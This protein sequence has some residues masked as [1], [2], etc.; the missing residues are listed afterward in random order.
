MIK[1][2][3]YEFR[4][5]LMSKLIFVGITVVMEIVFLVGLFG[6]F[7]KTMV[8]GMLGLFFTALAGIAFMGIESI[9]TLNRDLTTKQSYMLFMTP[10][11][12]YKILGAKALENG[13]AVLL[14]GAFFGGLAALDFWL[15]GREIDEVVNIVDMLRSMLETIDPRLV[16]SA[17]VLITV[18]FTILCSFLLRI[19]TGYLAV[20]LANTL[21]SGKR[22]A[23]IIAFVFFI[24]ISLAIGWV[25]NH[26]P[27]MNDT[28]NTMLLQSAFALACSVIMYFVTAWIM[29][30]KLSV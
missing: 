5:S 29:D 13:I 7:E 21:L 23:T 14:S 3:K 25:T 1:L 24:V 11:S 16:I 30:K 19:V 8:I 4:K 9:L 6:K 15:I 20:V 10:N 22:G 17:R 2:M 18:L 12:S 28:V 26:L 27:S